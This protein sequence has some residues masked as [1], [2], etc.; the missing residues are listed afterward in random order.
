[1]SDSV[2]HQHVQVTLNLLPFHHINRISVGIISYL[3]TSIIGKNKN[4][5]LSVL[6][7]DSNTSY[8]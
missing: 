8:V 7:L 1:M 4:V 6:Q 5:F 2:F 3:I